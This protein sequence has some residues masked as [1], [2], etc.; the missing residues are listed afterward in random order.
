M[1]RIPTHALDLQ[2]VIERSA[3]LNSGPQLH[4][5]LPELDG[6]FPRVAMQGR[7][8]KLSEAEESAP[9]LQVLTETKGMIG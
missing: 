9:I 6:K 3:V 4:V 7:G 2:N 1:E 5:V 8:L